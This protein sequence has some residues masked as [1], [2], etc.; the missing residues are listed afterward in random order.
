MIFVNPDGTL[1]HFFEPGGGEGCDY[2]IIRRSDGGF[3]RC[4][5]EADQ[6]PDGGRVSQEYV[7]R[8]QHRI[9]VLEIDVN[10]LRRQSNL[11]CATTRQLLAEL[12]AR[13]EI[14]YSNGGGGLDYSTVEGR[15]DEET[16]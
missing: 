5:F 1:A 11:G 13:I 3:E 10:R 14:D 15:P 8:L 7:D 9:N 4:G 12:S 16:P 2:L 6:H